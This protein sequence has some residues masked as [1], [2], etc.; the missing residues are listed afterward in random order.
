MA[1]RALI[2]SSRFPWP[3]FTGDRVRAVAWLEALAPRAEV[4]LVAPAGE[5]PPEA[6]RLHLV[7]ARRAPW[8]LAAAAVRTLASRLPATALLAA[9]YD[10]RGALAAAERDGGPFDA[11]VVLLAR[12][13]P[14]VY[15]GLR[16][17]RLVFD[18][19]DS[20][21]ANLDERAR[22]ARG[23]ARAAWRLEAR[24]TARLEHDAGKRYHRV[25]VSAEA[26]RAAFGP[27]TA[28]VSHGIVLL[29][30]VDGRRDFDIGFWG[31]LAYF[32]NR[33]AAL[34]LLD[35]IWPRIRETRPGATLL[36][37]GAD[38]PRRL[39]RRHGRDGIT[40]ISPMV[41]PAALLRRV[42]VAVFPLRFGTGQSNKV[43]EAAEASCALVATPAA[44]RGLE[45]LAAEAAVESEPERLAS[46]ALGLLAEPAT[47][48]AQGRRLRAVAERHFARAAACGRLAEIAL[49]RFPD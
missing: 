2:V 8:R 38:V 27:A 9:G 21:A 6:P 20:L 34:E 45:A 10:W 5:V 43:L 35:Q 42:K 12:L 25:L 31:R 40:V 13:D 7:A 22:A 37:A 11:A 48:A 33:N 4:T 24:R 44:V 3:A 26:E 16:G 41:Q 47:A 15:D 49:G 39:R 1:E 36:L 30:V 14:W 28:A 23:P 19:I 32:A 17:R 29:P 18:A 46:R